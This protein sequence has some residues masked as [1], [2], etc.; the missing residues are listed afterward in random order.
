MSLDVHLNRKK[1]V[2]YDNGQTFKDE[3]DEVYWANITHNLGTMAREAG[4]YEAL[5]R[6]YRLKPN[7]NIPEGDHKAE[8]KFEEDNPSVAKDII[9]VLEKG[10][11]DLKSRPEHFEKFNASNGWGLYK[12]F[13]PF[14]EEYLAACKEHPDAEIY[15][16][17]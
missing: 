3:V 7:Y 11:A 17:R 4:I 9:D 16:Y 15:C 8:Y 1:I 6:P 12:H 14:V 5:W 13:V 2:S 10:L